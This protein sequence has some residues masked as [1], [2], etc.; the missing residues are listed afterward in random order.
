[1]RLLFHLKPICLIV[2]IFIAGQAIAQD[3]IFVDWV[4][5]LNLNMQSY[6][7]ATAVLGD[8]N[9]VYV[10]VSANRFFDEYDKDILQLYGTK[11]DIWITKY[12]EY[13]E[14]L[15]SQQIRDSANS[16]VTKMDVF[17]EVVLLFGTTGGWK[18]FADLTGG[19]TIPGRSSVDPFLAIYNTK[20]GDLIKQVDV[21]EG[22]AIVDVQFDE[23]GRIWLL[24]TIG[25]EVDIDLG[26]GEQLMNYTTHP[27]FTG[28]FSQPDMAL[29]C[30]DQN[31]DLV[32]YEHFPCYGKVSPHQVSIDENNIWLRAFY[33]SSIE[34]DTIVFNQDTAL[35][36]KSN[37]RGVLIHL[38]TMAVV[39]GALVLDESAQIYDIQ[40]VGNELL[41]SG[42]YGLEIS[43]LIDATLVSSSSPNAWA[44]YDGSELYYFEAANIIGVQGKIEEGYILSETG[45]D[46]TVK[47]LSNET[48]QF[49]KPIGY[50]HLSFSL[51]V[52]QNPITE[53]LAYA[54]AYYF[55]L[56][57]GT[58]EYP[59][60]IHG[61]ELGT[62]RDFYFG[63]LA[64]D[65]P[66]GIVDST[67][68]PETEIQCGIHSVDQE[69]D[70]RGRGLRYQWYNTRKQDSLVDAEGFDRCGIAQF[71]RGATGKRL[72]YQWC[73][74]DQS[75]EGVYVVQV[76][77]GC[78]NTFQTD[79]ISIK[80][81]GEPEVKGNTVINGIEWKT[82]DTLI[83]EV[84]PV[85]GFDTVVYN[86]AKNDF[87]LYDFGRW[88]GTTSP[89]FELNGIGAQ[90]AGLYRCYA[91]HP[92]CPE[93]AGK[94]IDLPID[95]TGDTTVWDEWALGVADL[96]PQDL[97]EVYPSVF[98]NELK[99]IK[100][101]QSHDV[102]YQAVDLK[103]KVHQSGRLNFG[104]SVINSS[105]WPPGVYLLQ[106][107]SEIGFQQLKLVKE[108]E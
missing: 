22:L 45:Q 59:L 44:V 63:L 33:L 98:D 43:G 73:V 69:L 57:L 48:I 89:R 13:G 70:I 3:S 81:Y 65:C 75:I 4:R 104:R 32:R 46:I 30:L 10:S 80:S 102:F 94:N 53:N 28:T 91:F 50:N 56:N 25:G 42:S 95:I 49:I 34:T 14:R 100:T 77:D 86:W 38:D 90:D 23:N 61:P 78:G 17:E 62:Q 24:A 26:T 54:G 20:T 107:K 66:D 40:A 88:V 99:I 97:V 8:D 15:W 96:V 41:F 108:H 74:E 52:I 16:G 103:G 27:D 12:T 29:I 93:F 39:T 68:Y 1:M 11:Q 79:T 19:D 5:E 35:I 84:T 76:E 9:S 55:D 31:F 87:F 92:S 58:E 7:S 18:S 64:T 2:Y 71:I 106:V 85:E 72:Q 101:S 6:Q 83:L 82:G 67:V 36:D 37:D 105:E 51:G 60:V 47:S 21:P